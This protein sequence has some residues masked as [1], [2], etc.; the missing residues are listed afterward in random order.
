MLRLIPAPLMRVGLRIAYRVR[1][2]WRKLT[3]A[4]LAGV[5]VVAR[6]IDGQILL[7]RHSYG[8]AGWYIP[9]G[10]LKRGEDP[11]EAV[12]RELQE[13]IGC[14]IGAL[15]LLARVEERL[16]G[17][18]HTAHVY[19]GVIDDMPRPDGR[20]VVEARFFPTHSLPEPLGPRTRARLN[21]YLRPE[22]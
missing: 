18:S 19:T 7:V 2:R 11:E 12:R 6:D 4:K 16:S 3:G 14:D 21:L 17:S 5:C 13:E 8:P 9:G 22:R 1:H 10:G 15:S 20:E